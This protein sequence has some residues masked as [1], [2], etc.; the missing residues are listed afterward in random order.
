MPALGEIHGP[1]LA[2]RGRGGTG[3]RNNH[4]KIY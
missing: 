3:A 1:S 4:P 2:E